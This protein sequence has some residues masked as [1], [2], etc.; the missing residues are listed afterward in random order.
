MRAFQYVM[1]C[2]LTC[3]LAGLVAYSIHIARADVKTAQDDGWKPVAS[4]EVVAEGEY[5]AWLTT[6]QNV[7]N[8]TAASNPATAVEA[9]DKIADEALARAQA[10]HAEIRKQHGL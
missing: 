1:V 8:G 7:L 4:A 6:F 2:I 10:K 9:A 5:A 3:V